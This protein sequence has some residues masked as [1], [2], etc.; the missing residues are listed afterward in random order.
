MS[1]AV[2][3]EKLCRSSDSDSGTLLLAEACCHAS[4]ALRPESDGSERAFFAVAFAPVWHGYHGSSPPYPLSKDFIS[5]V[6]E[7]L[8]VLYGGRFHPGETWLVDDNKR[9]RPRLLVAPVGER[10]FQLDASDG[11]S[12]EFVWVPRVHASL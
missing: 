10:A 8:K 4:P 6:P 5:R 3:E 2:N 9:F 1:D 7:E 12:S 11:A